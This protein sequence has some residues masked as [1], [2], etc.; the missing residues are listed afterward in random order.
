[1]GARSN[2]PES[3]G[4]DIWKLRHYRTEGPSL[5]SGGVSAS[6][7]RARKTRREVGPEWSLPM[8]PD[9]ST[10]PKTGQLTGSMVKQARFQ[11]NELPSF[12]SWW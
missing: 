4:R 7:Q 8:S 3:L 2:S 6:E 12:F 11:S 9:A 10:L 1:M 5:L